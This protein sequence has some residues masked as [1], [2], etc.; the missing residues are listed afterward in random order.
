[1]VNDLTRN[2]IKVFCNSNSFFLF[3]ICPRVFPNSLI[4]LQIFNGVLDFFL[5]LNILRVRFLSCFFN[6]LQSLNLINFNF[7]LLWHKSV[8][9]MLEKF[10]WVPFEHLVKLS[11]VLIINKVWDDVLLIW[12]LES[13]DYLFSHFTGYVTFRICN[14]LPRFLLHRFFWHCVFTINSSLFPIQWFVISSNLF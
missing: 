2:E 7:S 6:F 11:E 1:L 3:R 5:E 13:A 4:F 8:V 10:K 14:Q 9:E 12:M